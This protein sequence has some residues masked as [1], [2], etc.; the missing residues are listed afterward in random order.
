M[1]QII[2]IR[3]HFKGIHLYELK[4]VHVYM[5]MCTCIIIF[6]FVNVCTILPKIFVDFEVFEESQ[7]FFWNIHHKNQFVSF[8]LRMCLAK[9]Y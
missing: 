7:I 2:M 8:K 4:Y 3:E 1:Q 9:V 5:C 6:V